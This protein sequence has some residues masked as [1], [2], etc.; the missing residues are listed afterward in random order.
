ML[1]EFRHHIELRTEDLIR[2]GLPPREAVRQ[3]EEVQL[4]AAAKLG[5]IPVLG[6]DPLGCVLVD[7]AGDGLLEQ[8]H[9]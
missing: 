2:R 9:A 3:D 6:V 7:E 1:D 8:P 5:E 4:Q